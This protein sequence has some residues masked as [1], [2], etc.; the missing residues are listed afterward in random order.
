MN[1][2]T[3]TETHALWTKTID[4]ARNCGWNGGKFLA[5]EMETGH[6]TDWERVMIA[7][8][9]EKI[10]AFCT[11]TR[12]DCMPDSP[13]TPFLG[14]LFVAEEHR[15]KRLGQALLQYATDYLTSLGFQETYICTDHV[16]L[17]EKYGFSPIGQAALPWGTETIFRKRLFPETKG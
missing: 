6:I 10:I 17:Y 7:M 8:E 4:Y 1:F 11:A 16:G 2:I 12:K 15:G 3:L 9:E 13:Y 14:S 5:M